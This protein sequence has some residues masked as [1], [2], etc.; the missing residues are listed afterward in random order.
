MLERNRTAVRRMQHFWYDIKI[1]TSLMHQE[2]LQANRTDTKEGG[3][4]SSIGTL[5]HY[6]Y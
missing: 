3:N 1:S 4:T 5:Y 2:I 6:Q